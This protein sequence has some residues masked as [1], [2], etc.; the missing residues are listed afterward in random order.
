[1]V[2]LESLACGVPVVS[3]RT[4]STP[5][6]LTPGEDGYL[7]ERDARSIAHALRDIRSSSTDF[8]AKAQATAERHNWS[9]VAL[10]YLE[11][12]DRVLLEQRKPVS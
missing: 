7:A 2:V 8:S 5:D 12:F 10:R 11:V 4:G 6:V 9:A 3:T 1:M